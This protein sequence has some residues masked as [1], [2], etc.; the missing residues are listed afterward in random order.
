MLPDFEKPGVIHDCVKVL[1]SI[2]SL[3]PNLS[4]LLLIDFDATL[5]TDGST[6]IHEGTQVAGVAVTTEDTVWSA[7]LAP[8]TFTQKAELMVLTATDK[9]YAFA[10]VHVHGV[11]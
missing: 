9:W 3:Q 5:F 11:I 4:H 10:T 2:K 7:S 8:G 6:Y 1:N